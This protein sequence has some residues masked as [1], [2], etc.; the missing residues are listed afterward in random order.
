M[1]KSVRF[2]GL[3]LIT[4]SL[5]QAQAEKRPNIIFFLTDDQRFD[6]LGCA[7]HPILLTPHID[8]LAK[9]GTRFENTIVTTST[10]WISRA[11]MF[12]GLTWRGHRY[13]HRPFQPMV[14]NSYPAMLK[15]AGYQV[16]YVGKHH[17]K[18][19]KEDEEKMFHEFTKVGRNPFFS[20]S[21]WKDRL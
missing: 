8:R 14:E 3:L 19:T 18:T 7:G 13:P 12:S 4:L 11:T 2:L 21:F 9:E 10:C 17:V 20:N 16:G 1:I 15:K 5:F 6:F